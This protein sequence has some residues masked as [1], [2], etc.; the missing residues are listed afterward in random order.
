MEDQGAEMSVLKFDEDMC[1]DEVPQRYPSPNP[2]KILL[3][4]PK[5]PFQTCNLVRKEPMVQESTK[6]FIDEEST[7]N[8][9]QSSNKR[10]DIKAQKSSYKYLVSMPL[11]AGQIYKV[12]LPKAFF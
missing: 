1:F 10:T 7:G 11:Q 5:C 12:Y 4:G 2:D 6:V 9:S 8:T 3:D